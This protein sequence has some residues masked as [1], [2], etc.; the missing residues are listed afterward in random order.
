VATPLGEDKVLIR[1]F[2]ATEQLGRP[3][4]IELELLSEDGAIAALDM[5]GQRVTL[6]VA[7]PDG[8]TRYLNG[9]V[10]RWYQ[11]TPAGG[12]A[13]YRATL[14]PWV[15]LLTR[16]ANCRIFQEKSIPDIVKQVFRDHGFSDFQDSLNG[17]YDALEYCVQ[18]R[19]TDFNFV[20]RLLEQ[21]GIYYYFKH[22]NGKH[23]M[24]LADSPSA[25]KPYGAY[26]AITYH[27]PDRVVAGREFITDWSVEQRV[28]TG[29]FAH[30]DFD[31]SKPDTNLE[32]R[33]Q[34]TV[35]HAGSKFEVFDYPGE[36]ATAALGETLAKV[37]M[38][39]M[40]AEHER[41]QGETDSRGVS[42]GYKFTLKGF[43]RDDQNKEWLVT[44]TTIHAESDAYEGG[45]AGGAGGGSEIYRA[46]FTVI[47]AATQFRPARVTPKPLI[48]GPQTAIV[49]GKS[50]EEIWTDKHG[51]VKVQ[52]HW[53][54]EA[55]GDETTSCWV[56][57]AQ[58]WAGKKYGGMFIPRIGHEVIVE[59]LE[60]DPDRPIVTGCVYNAREAPAYP[61]PDNMTRSGVKTNSSKG[62]GGFNEI[63]FEDKKGEEQLFIH[64]EKQLDMR[65]KQ[66]ALEWIG[67]DRHRIVV[68][69]AKEEVQNNLHLT[70]TGDHNEKAGGNRSQIV[71][72]DRMAKIDG[73]DH[74]KV[75][76]D[77]LLKATG[78]H[79]VDAQAIHI[80]AGSTVVIE[81]DSQ[82]SLKV[83][84]NFV[85]ISSGGVDIVGTAVKINSGGSAASGGGCSPA[86]ADAPEAPTEA[87]TADPGEVSAPPEG[88]EHTIDPQSFT[89][90]TT[91]LMQAAD[92]GTPFCEECER[93]RQEDQA[94][95]EREAEQQV[96]VTGEI[97]DDLDEQNNWT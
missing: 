18:Y 62:G 29:K 70:V 65:I 82:I 1:S 40:H 54:R 69:D 55:K 81:A 37:R 8:E 79:A 63:R 64:G 50:G 95:R 93:A 97:P 28:Q 87:A 91:V 53:D 46:S 78:N 71:T 19:E 89:P 92:E 58:T 13:R 39:E 77:A 33:S 88:R 49:T 72:G 59:F 10:S 85:N 75:G 32:T 27:A 30:T 5:L 67:N 56:R 24:V 21:V 41:A 61:L 2:T 57:V 6:R 4:R 86:D 31:F 16:A 26:S 60:G 7:Q 84:G 66:D 12:M 73:G 47:D 80:K 48:S 43:P 90:A 36:Y 22:E 51:R 34:S 38:E 25:H 20:S 42:V 11:T 14:V 15:W 9:H 45:G 44:S 83:G 3:F 96:T 23:T 52:F 94:A 68:N 76:G 17:T 74:V 35:T